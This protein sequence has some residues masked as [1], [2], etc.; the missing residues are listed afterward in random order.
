MMIPLTNTWHAMRRLS[1]SA[2][3][4]LALTTWPTRGLAAEPAST[5]AIAVIDAAIASLREKPN[6]FSV[7]VSVQGLV[8]NNAGGVGFQANPTITGGSGNVT[9]YK[10]DGGASITVAQNVANDAATKQSEETVRL[11]EQ[12]RDAVQKDD[13]GKANETLVML[14]SK[15]ID[16]IYKI[17]EVVVRRRLGLPM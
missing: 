4:V 14:K 3:L 15:A 17:I 12:I 13:K 9:G 10:V 8:A 7:S 11:L 2:T 6:Q 16:V 1:Q 5:E